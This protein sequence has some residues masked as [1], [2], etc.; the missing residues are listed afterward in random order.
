MENKDPK[1]VEK[2]VVEE[3]LHRKGLIIAGP[4]S[5]ESEEQLLTTALQL[6]ETGKVNILRAG[7][8]KP[9]TNPGGFEGLGTKSLPWLLKAKQVSGLPTAVE[10]ATSKHVEDALSF[11]V[12]VLWIGARTSVNPFSV[13]N[14]A[15]ALK[16][17]DIPVLIKNPVNPDLKLWIGA[18]ERIQKA[19][20]KTIGLIHRGFSAY[21]N[22]EYR[23]SP[24]WQIPIEM[25]RHFPELPM[26]CDPSHICGNRDGLLSV[27][28]KSIDLD[29]DGLIIESHYDP[30]IALTDKN[31]QLKPKDLE[32]LFNNL[33]WKQRSSEE[34]NYLQKLEELREQINLIDDDL[35]QQISKRMEIAKAIGGLK[36]E[37]KVT[38]LQPGRYNEII[39]KAIK[40]AQTKGLS[41]DFIKTYMEAIHIESIRIQNTLQ[42]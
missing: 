10:V 41:E 19:G 33:Q 2:K 42:A 40:K 9:R 4:C 5:V 3:I 34:K 29:Y 35:I 21:G 13:Q 31:Q 28:Q 38:I 7:I 11:D 12:D 16:G 39:E 24:I 18:V 17:T 14:I 23:N 27:S 20:V 25:K 30:E 8:W 36:K 37:N 15:D 22:T 6:A 32:N 1:Q 26:I